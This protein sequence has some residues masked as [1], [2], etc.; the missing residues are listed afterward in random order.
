M[1]SKPRPT[2]SGDPAA[3]PAVR[4]TAAARGVDLKNVKGTGVGGRI[5]IADV[6]AA[7]PPPPPA[8]RPAAYLRPAGNPVGA[9]LAHERPAEVAAARQAGLREPTLF[10]SGELPPFTA[11][12]LDPSV[13]LHVPWQARI[14]VARATTVVEAYSLLNEYAGPDGDEAAARDFA[15]IERDL[16]DRYHAW[17]LSGYSDDQM[18]ESI[19][20][21][22]NPG[23]GESKVLSSTRSST[24]WVI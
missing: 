14:A 10:P 23:R 5:T 24:E 15:D 8:V 3:T 1:T 9:R 22:S 19:G 20:W 12:G 2:S 4:A 11:S 7:A 18:L 13:L 21:I 16:E 17:L 6:K